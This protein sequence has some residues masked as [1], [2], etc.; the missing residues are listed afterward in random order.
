MSLVA[1]LSTLPVGGKFQM[2][3][4]YVRDLDSITA[5]KG[6]MANTAGTAC[7]RAGIRG[8]TTTSAVVDWQAGWIVVRAVVER[9]A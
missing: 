4:S 8:R 1:H 7:R 6:R 2:P 9:L 3:E 5:V